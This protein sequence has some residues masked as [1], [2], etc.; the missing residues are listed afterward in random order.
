[1]VI[2]S[3]C[4]EKYRTCKLYSDFCVHKSGLSLSNLKTISINEPNAFKEILRVFRSENP[5][6]L[7]QLPAVFALFAPPNPA[8]V[9]A[10]NKGKSRLPGKNYGS[11]VGSLSKY[12]SN[13]APDAMPPTIRSGDQLRFIEGAFLHVQFT[14]PDFN[15]STIRNGTHL[16]LVMP[17]GVHRKLYTMLEML[18]QAD[19]D[20]NLY[21]GK[22]YTAPI[23]TSANLSGQGSIT[24]L[25]K[26]I[27]FGEARE[28]PLFVSY[29]QMNE[30]KGS[31]PIF[32]FSGEKVSILRKG[33]GLERIRKQF[34][35]E[36]QFSE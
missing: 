7:V 34:P 22:H 35:P 3:L 27:E 5:I 8:G 14:N 36:F 1:M 19:A 9:A 13:F 18:M 10:L 4:I 28:I 12:F 20:P 2:P 30:D 33:P 25:G 11:A 17:E 26:A 21:N 16:G 15:S 24:E 6:V 29:N 31:F 32:S 23:C